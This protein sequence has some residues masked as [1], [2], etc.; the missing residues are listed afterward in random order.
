M[1]DTVKRHSLK[2]VS[3]FLV[4]IIVAG[5]IFVVNITTTHAEN[6]DGYLEADQINESARN[7]SKDHADDEEAGS[8]DFPHVSGAAAAFFNYRIVK[9]MDEKDDKYLD[10]FRAGNEAYIGSAGDAGSYLGYVSQ[11]DGNLFGF[12]VSAFTKAS[13]SY[14]YN[15][16][17]SFGLTNSK[18]YAY[19]AYGSM[20]ST[21]GLDKTKNVSTSSNFGSVIGGG[22]MLVGYLAAS[23]IPRLFSWIVD[24]LNTL[25]PFGLLVNS[26][27]NGT[28]SVSL[29]GNHDVSST[30]TAK[31]GGAFDTLR[32]YYTKLI[33]WMTKFS[34]Y[35]IIPFCIA[36]LVAGFLLF[37]NMGATKSRAKKLLIRIVFLAIG[38]PLLGTM[39]TSILIEMKE[40][41]DTPMTAP[42]VVVASTIVDFNAWANSSNLLPPK[43]SG[44]AEIA[45][46]ITDAETHKIEPTTST[47]W[48]LKNYCLYL[49]SQYASYLGRIDF[50][51]DSS[52]DTESTISDWSTA[53]LERAKGKNSAIINSG[54]VTL[55]VQYM[56]GGVVTSG[57]YASNIVSRH[58]DTT[59]TEPDAALVIMFRN[60]NAFK[61]WK[62]NWVDDAGDDK[63]SKQINQLCTDSQYGTFMTN[64]GL[65]FHP[66]ESHPDGYGGYTGTG[67]SFYTSPKEWYATRSVRDSGKFPLGLSDMAMYNYLNTEFKSTEA[68]VYSP[69]DT[70]SYFSQVYHSSVNCIGR[71]FL[72]FM[73]MF[74]AIVT[75]FVYAIIGWFYAFGMFFQ[76]LKRMITLLVKIP[77]AAL[78]VM[79]SMAQ[80][81]AYIVAMIVE[82]MATILMY[83]IVMRL[84]E[85]IPRIIMDGASNLFSTDRSTS[86]ASL[87]ITLIIVSVALI[88]FGVTAIKARKT[89]IKAI[90]EGLNGLIGRVFGTDN[91]VPPS[92]PKGHPIRDGLVTGAAMAA[93]NRLMGGAGAAVAGRADDDGVSGS[94]RSDDDGGEYDDPD[95]EENTEEMPEGLPEGED[96]VSEEDRGRDAFDSDSL[97][98][99]SERAALP[100]GGNGSGSSGSDSHDNTN[101]NSNVE[102]GEGAEGAAS[103]ARNAA[104]A[105]SADTAM[106]A[107]AR[108]AYNRAIANGA[109]EQ[110]AL[111]AAYTAAGGSSNTTAARKAALGA[112]A[113][114][115]Q[116]AGVAGQSISQAELAAQSAYNQAKQNGAS[117]E[118]A[119]AA[120]ENVRMTEQRRVKA[121]Q[122]ADMAYDRARA[123][124][125]SNAQALAASKAA[126]AGATDSALSP[127]AAAKAGLTGDAAMANAVRGV[128]AAGQD[129]YQKALMRGVS[130]Q[131]AEKLRIKG[132]TAAAK[133]YGVKAAEVKAFD[134]QQ[135]RVVTAN[136]S[137]KSAADSAYFR[138]LSNNMTKQQAHVVANEAYNNSLKASGVT[139]A[140]VK[141]VRS[142]NDTVNAAVASTVQTTHRTPT[143]VGVN[144]P[145]AQQQHIRR[146]TDVIVD[147]VTNVRSQP[148][149]ISG[150]QHQQASPQ[151]QQ[152][153]GSQTHVRRDTDVIVDDV[154]NVRHQNGRTNVTGN[155]GSGGYYGGGSENTSFN[156]P[157]NNVPARPDTGERFS[158]RPKSNPNSLA[159]G[160]GRN[161]RND[162]AGQFIDNFD[163]DE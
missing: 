35:I 39:Y 56:A 32:E 91:L 131:D 86:A 27:L 2:L 105:S 140:Q 19:C 141:A 66:I 155:G 1:I 109:T 139:D 3:L 24:V 71:G 23:S 10:M 81:V 16:A 26:D 128:K 49:N 73:F 145:Q 34:W 135:Q 127:T 163:D 134:Q 17:Y 47:Y 64:G 133:Q 160:V 77:A 106:D 101:V 111:N 137:A 162:D 146:E 46:E 14:S 37:K 22:I 161:I 45:G 55:I 153:F 149:Q 75:L 118:A 52:S 80:V 136:A 67:F 148:S 69:L 28:G 18:F 129:A 112:R 87:Y 159:G 82:I 113:A 74:H 4:L 121:T 43:S 30:E 54:V 144:V 72:C 92:E 126:Y 104:P 51:D 20:L 57:A 88:I 68:I 21:L 143:G 59:A 117:D 99:G 11:D 53:S 70:V 151:Q 114:H 12:L 50:L 9:S 78:G 38:I 63:N 6:T 115:T 89:I 96:A 102:L 31:S 60:M 58:S 147:D 36:I 116:R 154:T 132:E 158:S 94:E 107:R 124:G 48:S 108:D 125:A 120:A 110:Q 152:R 13:A 130:V 41:V 42:D 83:S 123:N 25:N 90:D 156:G 79:R 62:D 157:V 33:D 97:A 100:G 7:Y 40:V 84:M 5:S 142:N 150:G 15:M 65:D 95:D 29:S 44:G 98:A 76:N 8:L 93:G 61:K 119:A 85:A 138:A 122:T 103:D